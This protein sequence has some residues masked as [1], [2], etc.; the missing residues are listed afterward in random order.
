MKTGETRGVNPYFTEYQVQGNRLL[1][2]VQ[3]PKNST[4][5]TRAIKSV[6]PDFKGNLDNAGHLMHQ[7]S[8]GKKPS[9][10]YWRKNGLKKYEAPPFAFISGPWEELFKVGHNVDLGL[11]IMS[12]VHL[13][14]MSTLD[15]S[16]MHAFPVR[17]S[18]FFAGTTENLFFLNNLEETD[19]PG[20]RLKHPETPVFTPQQLKHL[21]V[22]Q[23]DALDIEHHALIRQ[24]EEAVKRR[25]PKETIDSLTNRLLA[26]DRVRL[27][28]P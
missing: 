12:R 28:R 18:I 21:T 16:K 2:L 9:E 3:Q 10:D 20:F 7:F 26:A 11:I 15:R 8:E 14:K 5:W 25:F 19:H 4:E 23:Y 27:Q 22:A 13:E 1:E 17:G 24:K 6:Y